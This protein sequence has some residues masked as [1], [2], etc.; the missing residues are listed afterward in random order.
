MVSD[1]AVPDGLDINRHDLQGN[2]AGDSQELVFLNKLALSNV[3]SLRHGGYCIKYFFLQLCTEG[4]FGRAHLSGLGRW[5]LRAV[6]TPMPGL[7]TVE[8]ELATFLNIL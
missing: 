6:K 3:E 4:T 1:E 7:A 2:I 8:L 5:L